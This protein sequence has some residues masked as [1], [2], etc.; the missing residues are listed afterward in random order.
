MTNTERTQL[1]IDLAVILGAK[2]QT[3]EYGDFLKWDMSH[4]TPLIRAQAFREV[5]SC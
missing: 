3:E 5:L 4:G 1:N 2:W